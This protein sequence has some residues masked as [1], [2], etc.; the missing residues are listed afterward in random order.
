[1]PK[2]D[3]ITKFENNFFQ[4]NRKKKSDIVLWLL[5]IWDCLLFVVEG[6]ESKIKNKSYFKSL[7][8]EKGN[9]Q[10]LS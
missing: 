4:E 5:H 1:M 6:A 7:Y 8:F 10:L 2:K 3:V 9:D